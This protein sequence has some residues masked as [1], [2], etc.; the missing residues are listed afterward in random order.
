LLVE[1]WYN[2]LIIN[3]TRRQGVMDMYANLD[4]HEFVLLTLSLAAALLDCLIV[5]FGNKF[6][7]ENAKQVL[8]ACKQRNL[9]IQ[10]Y[11]SQFKSIFYLVEDVEEMRT[12]QQRVV[13]DPDA[14]EIDSARVAPFNAP[15]FLLLD[16]SRA[17]CWAQQ[18]CFQCFSPIVAGSHTGSL[19]CP[20]P[21][22]S[23]EQREAFVKHF[24]LA[25]LQL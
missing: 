6:M 4:R 3:N 14:I 23:P 16:A 1:N 2:L 5:V 12:P 8:A 24:L 9:T 11:N 10:K 20:N 18:L 7:R 13:K 22:V 25:P 17:I 19:N 21:A 15:S